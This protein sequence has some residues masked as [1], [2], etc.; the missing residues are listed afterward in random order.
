MASGVAVL[1]RFGAGEGQPHGPA[2]PLSSSI[3]DLA[4]AGFTGQHGVVLGRTITLPEG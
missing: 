1:I 4:V 2:A 3:A